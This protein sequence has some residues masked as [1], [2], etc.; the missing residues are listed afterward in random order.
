MFHVLCPPE[1]VAIKNKNLVSKNINIIKVRKIFNKLDPP[2][3]E[4]VAIKSNS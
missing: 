1:V 2:A 4:V 3:I